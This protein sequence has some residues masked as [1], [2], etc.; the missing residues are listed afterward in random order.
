MNLLLGVVN[1]T[2]HLGIVHHRLHYKMTTRLVK[3]LDRDIPPERCDC[4]P[5]FVDRLSLATN[6]VSD[7]K[8]KQD[9]GDDC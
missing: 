1:K 2:H 8:W 4:S 3:L 6:K 7:T 9:R 5:R